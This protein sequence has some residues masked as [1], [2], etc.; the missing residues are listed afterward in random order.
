MDLLRKLPALTATAIL[1]VGL[2]FGPIVGLGQLSQT[3]PNVFPGD[4]S[5]DITIVSV[6]VE[7]SL[8]RARYASSGYGLSIPPA[9]VDV[10]NLSGNPMVVYKFRFPEMDYV[11]GTNHV[12]DERFTGRQTLALGEPVLNRTSFG[13]DTYQGELVV[14][15]RVHEC[16]TVLYRRNVTL[17]VNR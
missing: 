6:P 7:G 9:T 1:I 8:D 16:D 4:G 10:S 12:L 3:E 2:L 13:R 14:I 17:R 15:K 11:T 5:A